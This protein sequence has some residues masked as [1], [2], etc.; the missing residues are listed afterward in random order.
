MVI[1]YELVR[2]QHD[3]RPQAESGDGVRSAARIALAASLLCVAPASALEGVDDNNSALRM[4]KMTF[5]DARDG[6]TE[7][8]LDAERVYLPPRSDVAQLEGIHVRMAQAR[9]IGDSLVMTC[10]RGDMVLGKSD[11]RAEGDVRGR[12]GDGRQFF[13]TWV[14]YDS[15]TQ[16][17]ST[18]APVRILDGFHT[19]QGVGLR[20]NV[21]DGRLAITSGATVVQ[22]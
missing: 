18:D 13:T 12:T 16:I 14:R 11:F 20:Y 7:V 2:P 15:D 1:A 10:E 5:V 22:E 9:S 8:V 19:L 17:L 4:S 3:P 21:R 6:H